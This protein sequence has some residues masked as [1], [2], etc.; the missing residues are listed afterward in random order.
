MRPGFLGKWIE[1]ASLDVGEYEDIIQF[2]RARFLKPSLEQKAAQ[3][4]KDIHLNPDLIAEQK[5]IEMEIMQGQ[6]S[7]KDQRRMREEAEVAAA[8]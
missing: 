4:D 2:M 3:F 1:F 6:M 7:Q 8:V 5:R